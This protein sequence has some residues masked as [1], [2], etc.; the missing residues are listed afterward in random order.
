MVAVDKVIRYVG[1]SAFLPSGSLFHLFW[2]HTFIM[3][4]DAGEKDFVEYFQ[5]G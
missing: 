3:L 1:F 5:R 2:K 4:E